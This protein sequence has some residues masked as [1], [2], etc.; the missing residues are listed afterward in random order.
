VTQGDASG[1]NPQLTWMRTSM[2]RV[3]N[4]GGDPT[5][6]HAI[7]DTFLRWAGRRREWF[8]GRTVKAR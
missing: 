5:T 2:K 3:F 7:L 4:G 8:G 6:L 1:L